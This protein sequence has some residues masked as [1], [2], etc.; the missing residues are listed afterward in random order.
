MGYGSLFLCLSVGAFM[1]IC[2]Y[3]SIYH[4]D[5]CTE[6]SSFLGWRGVRRGRGKIR[7]SWQ[8]EFEQNTVIVINK[9][10]LT[11]PPLLC[12]YKFNNNDYKCKII[13]VYSACLRVLLL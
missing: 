2:I 5:K 13:N 8:G 4:P 1:Y 11:K 9:N 12:T 7:G 10:I 6:G 3:L